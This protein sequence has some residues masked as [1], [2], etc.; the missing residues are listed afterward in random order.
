MQCCQVFVA[1]WELPQVN[2]D[3]DLNENWCKVLLFLTSLELHQHLVELSEGDRHEHLTYPA[4]SPQVPEL[5][6]SAVIVTILLPSVC[7]VFYVLLKVPSCLA[8]AVFWGAERQ[9]DPST[10]GQMSHGLLAP[11][12]TPVSHPPSHTKFT[13][14]RGHRKGRPG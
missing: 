5:S 7:T 4:S 6:L 3:G 1:S 9:Q 14:R 2:S 12:S 10:W 8:P 13:H 11:G